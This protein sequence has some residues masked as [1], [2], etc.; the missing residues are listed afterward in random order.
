LFTTKKL[1]FLSY[2]WFEYQHFDQILKI[3]KEVPEFYKTLQQVVAIERNFVV[4]SINLDHATLLKDLLPAN[5]FV[6]LKIKGA[7]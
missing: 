2:K 6:S 5:G 1:A 7:E 3:A 4:P